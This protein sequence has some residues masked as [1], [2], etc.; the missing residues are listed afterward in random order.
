MMVTV[1][2]HFYAKPERRHELETILIGWPE[3]ARREPGWVDYCLH[4]SDN[5][6]NV[7][8]FYENWRSQRDFEKHGEMPYLK[9][10]LDRR[11]DYL[12]RDIEVRFYT[13][14]SPYANPSTAGDSKHGDIAR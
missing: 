11:M 8:M 12:T 14:L 3:L 6:P 7:L 13:M 9:N 5:D 1:I 10:F 2:A 4:R